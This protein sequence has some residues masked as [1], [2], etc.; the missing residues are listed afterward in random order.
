MEFLFFLGGGG[1]NKKNIIG[2]LRIMRAPHNLQVWPLFFFG[3]VKPLTPPPLGT[4]LAKGTNL[5]LYKETSH[6]TCQIGYLQEIAIDKWLQSRG[7]SMSVNIYTID[8]CGLRGEKVPR[9][10]LV[11]YLIYGMIPSPPNVQI[12]SPN[13]FLNYY[14]FIL[15]YFTF[16]LYNL[17]GG[18]SP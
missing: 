18:L 16:V 15:F 10:G 5:L 4:T 12:Y 9:L 6:E 3:G 17:G 11:T 8:F 13:F 14:K 2:Y 1:L 7:F